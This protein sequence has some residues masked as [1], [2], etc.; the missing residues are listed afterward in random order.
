MYDALNKNFFT[1]DLQ[2]DGQTVLI[3]IGAVS[4]ASMS[5]QWVSQSHG[6]PVLSDTSW[7]NSSEMFE[8]VKNV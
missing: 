6:V 3:S 7:S 1:Y 8:C 5:P 4:L 2:T